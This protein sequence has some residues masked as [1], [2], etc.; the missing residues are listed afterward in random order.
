MPISLARPPER[1]GLAAPL[2]RI[3]HTTLALQ[4][5]RPGEISIVL[6]D[7]AMLRELNRRYR[8]IDRATDVLSF[9]YG[10]APLVD[11]DLVVSLDRVRVQA[12]RYR[13]SDGRELARLL[14]HGAL[15]LCGLDHHRASERAQMR[16][17]ENEVMRGVAK[18][19]AAL[20]K[21]MGGGARRAARA[22]R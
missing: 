18:H 20:E 10:P 8:G 16:A 14:V 11:G 6:A 12:K 7:D 3:V 2:R 17:Q 5:R 19:V 4:G 22:H 15:H 13:V 9:E 21:A 1:P